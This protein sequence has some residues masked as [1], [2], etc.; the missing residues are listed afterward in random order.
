MNKDNFIEADNTSILSDQIKLRLNEINEIKDYFSSEIQE[1]KAISKTLSKYIPAFGYIDKT[2]IILSA[3]S[4]GV[5]IISFSSVI[6]TPAGM[7]S[8]SFTFAFSL[9]TGMINK[10]L[11][12]KRNKKKK[13]NKI[14][15]LAKNK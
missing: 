6:G 14:Y 8:V 2:L 12:I 9:T 11:Q 1:R 7:T 5:S 3:T 4:G 10:L 15:V 13:H